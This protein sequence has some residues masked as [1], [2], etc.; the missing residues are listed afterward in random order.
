MQT[1]LVMHLKETLTN[2]I[3]VMAWGLMWYVLYHFFSPT[4]SGCVRSTFLLPLAYILF[5]Q[6]SSWQTERT[7]LAGKSSSFESIIHTLLLESACI[8]HAHRGYFMSYCVQLTCCWKLWP[9]PFVA[10]CFGSEANTQT[11]FVKSSEQINTHA[12]TYI[13]TLAY[14]QPEYVCEKYHMQRI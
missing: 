8:F 13:Q 10:S 12:H 4:G 3:H 1:M 7:S 14:L 2:V 11:L 9:V 6:H 5:S